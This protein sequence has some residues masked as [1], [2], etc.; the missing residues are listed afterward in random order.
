MPLF[1]SSR[2]YGL[3]DAFCLKLFFLLH[4]QTLKVH[5]TL[6]ARSNRITLSL[7]II[8]YQV[9]SVVSDFPYHMVVLITWHI[10]LV[11]RCLATSLF[12]I[13]LFLNIH[14]VFQSV[15]YIFSFIFCFV[16]L[17][18]KNFIL[19]DFISIGALGFDKELLKLAKSVSRLVGV[20]SAFEEVFLKSDFAP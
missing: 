9:D 4:S 1:F 16:S 8:I 11:N 10:Q 6:L 17:E 14:I 5:H 13:W 7:L 3:S 12:K 20:G 18:N 15:P 19:W 2:W